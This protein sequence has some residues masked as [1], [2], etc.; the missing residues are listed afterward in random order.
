MD[1]AVPFPCND[2]AWQQSAPPLIECICQR[3]DLSI[4]SRRSNPLQE[5]QGRRVE[6]TQY[7]GLETVGNHCKQKV[8][9][10]VSGRLLAC[11]ALPTGPQSIERETAKLRDLL[12]QCA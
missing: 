6:V 5:P 10:H 3:S 9:G 11:H 2:R 4:R 8:P 12:V 1:V 7:I